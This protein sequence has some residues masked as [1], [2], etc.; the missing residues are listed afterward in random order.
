MKVKNK[1]WIVFVSMI[2]MACTHDIKNETVPVE[3]INFGSTKKVDIEEL[4][5]DTLTDYILLKNTNKNQLFGR[6]DKIKLCND[7]I[8]IADTRMRS[9]VVYGKNGVGI[10]K[11]GTV[12]QGPRELLSITDFDV[13]SLGNIYVLDG[14]LD[15]LLIYDNNFVCVKEKKLPFE[16]DILKVLGDSQI[17]FGLS[18][19]NKGK[20]AGTK[21]VI[22]NDTFE[23]DH[24][25]FEYTDAVDPAYW[26]SGYRFGESDVYIAYNQTVCNDVYVFNSV[27]D[28]KKI[29]R[30]DFDDENVLDD[31]KINIENKLLNYDKYTMLKNILTVTDKYIIGF[32]WEH[33]KTRMFILDY[34]LNI[35]Y[36]GKV[37]SDYDRR[38]GCGFCRD[39]LISYMDS[40]NEL[41]PD[42]VN[43]HLR[44]E[45]V[46]L[47][48]QS[49]K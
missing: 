37:I 47:K 34:V 36:L 4:L 30:F 7:R 17:L 18:S 11:V 25:Y 40:D 10:A 28:L 29:F 8:Y 5:C 35:C 23:I 14:R 46:V 26:I 21:I 16:A 39:G 24:E 19:W 2:F 15:K 44:N 3:F 13:D 45:G 6:I 41:Y 9:L 49:V 22:T 27:G 31:D 20:A 42:T 32:L 12:G 1:I 43:A 33:R 38:I 48:I